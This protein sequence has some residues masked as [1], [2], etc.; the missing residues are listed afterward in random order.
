MYRF[1][2]ILEHLKCSKSSHIF[3]LM[4]W[5]IN[6]IFWDPSNYTHIGLQEVNTRLRIIVGI[7]HE[8]RME[9]FLELSTISMF[10][11]LSECSFEDIIPS[12]LIDFLLFS[13]FRNLFES[14]EYSF[15]TISDE[16]M[17]FWS[18]LHLSISKHSRDVSLHCIPES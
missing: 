3:L 15:S 9:F 13:N 17:S 11:D 10:V 14:F 1:S 4:K 6:F 5:E 2:R 18:R 12:I 8:K 16:F 7:H